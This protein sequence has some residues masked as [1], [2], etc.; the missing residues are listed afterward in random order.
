MPKR[1]RQTKARKRTALAMYRKKKVRSLLSQKLIKPDI[2][3]RLI[4]GPLKGVMKWIAD[5]KYIEIDETKTGK[6]Q[7]EGEPA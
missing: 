2:A 3:H 7:P 1:C 5:K 4:M 6:D